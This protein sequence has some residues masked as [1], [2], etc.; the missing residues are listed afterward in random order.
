[1][2]SDSPPPHISE[3]PRKVPLQGAN[4]FR[5]LGGYRCSDGRHIRSG[6]IFRSDHLGNL[7]PED[8]QLLR[9]LNVKTVI[10]LRR[11]R[12]R[13]EKMNYPSPIQV[14]KDATDKAYEKVKARVCG[15]AFGDRLRRRID[16]RET[17][18]R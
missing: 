4:N 17:H 13:A 14:D 15:V 7:T 10:D 11:E 8:Q 12:E 5:D 16:V 18:E 6:R 9:Q 1:M 3:L 2:S